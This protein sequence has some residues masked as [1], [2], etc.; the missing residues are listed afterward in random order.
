MWVLRDP[1]L[2]ERGC[3]AVRESVARAVMRIPAVRVKEP[4]VLPVDKTYARDI[5][6]FN[7]PE[8][9]KVKSMFT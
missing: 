7:A 8:T 6:E 9:C 2:T 3:L 4:V 5:E 1:C